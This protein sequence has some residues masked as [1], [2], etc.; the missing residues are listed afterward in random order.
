MRERGA[1]GPICHRNPLPPRE[2]SILGIG[3]KSDS[4][5]CA[6]LCGQGC[7]DEVSFLTRWEPVGHSFQAYPPSLALSGSELWIGK[8]WVGH[9]PAS[10][11]WL[12]SRSQV[13]PQMTGNPKPYKFQLTFLGR[14][15]LGFKFSSP[16]SSQYSHTLQRWSEALCHH[17]VVASGCTPCICE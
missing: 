10:S 9:A 15:G 11:V 4:V 5:L 8:S 12:K 2:S 7:L 13:P 6:T 16:Q 17:L 14:S 3:H 1:I